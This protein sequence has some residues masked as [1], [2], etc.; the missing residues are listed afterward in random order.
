M[1]K[2]SRKPLQ[3]IIY[4]LL[5]ILVVTPLALIHIS[6]GLEDFLSHIRSM[7][8][9]VLALSIFILLLAEAVKAARLTII[10]EQL[11]L[12]ISFTAS[13]VARLSGRFIGVLTPAYAG[14]TPTRAIILSAYT[15]H[16]P[17]TTF[18]LAVMESVLDT[19]LPVAIAIIFAIPY[20]PSSWLILLV[21]ACLGAAWLLGILYAR[22]HALEKSILK[23]RLPRRAK[24]YILEQRNLF[25]R[26]MSRVI[27]PRV[28][29]PALGL[30]IVAHIIEAIALIIVIGEG[31]HI[32]PSLII[33]VFAVLEAS[34]VL[35]MSI[36]PGGAGFFEYGLAGILDPSSLIEWRLVYLAFSILPGF[37]IVATIKP[38]RSYIREAIERS[39][40]HE[41]QLPEAS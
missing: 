1:G 13:L 34:Y 41:C 20:L 15:K 37:I 4:G 26:W 39:E 27:S 24:C 7:S 6:G 8:L 12:P 23:S 38:V 29:L 32:T 22:S 36:T 21:A 10:G 17:G 5:F 3:R 18:G 28:F 31:S 9:R 35:T 33:Q 14:A 40:E 11:D 2:N 16:E 30:T 25:V 19:M